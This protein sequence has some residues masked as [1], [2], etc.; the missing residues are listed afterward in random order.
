MSDIYSLEDKISNIRKVVRNLTGDTFSNYEKDFRPALLKKIDSDSSRN[1]QKSLENFLE[2]K[3]QEDKVKVYTHPPIESVAEHT[4]DY[5]KE[6]KNYSRYSFK[7]PYSNKILTSFTSDD[8]KDLSSL[9]MHDKENSDLNSL[10][11]LERENVRKLELRI[12]KKDEIIQNMNE[13]QIALTN[14]IEL[15]RIKGHEGQVEEYKNTINI[16]QEKV[17]KY[18]SQINYLQSQQGRNTATPDFKKAQIEDLQNKILILERKNSELLSNQHDF[19]TI[20]S[21]FKQDQLIASDLKYQLE[22]KDKQVV[23]LMQ[24]N[25]NL[26]INLTELQSLKKDSR[27]DFREFKL[28]EEIQRLKFENEKLAEKPQNSKVP[29]DSSK[30][31]RRSCSSNIILSEVSNYLKCPSSE[32]ISRV[33]QLKH[34]EKLEI[35]LGKLLKDLSPQTAKLSTKQIWKCIRKVIEEYLLLKKRLETEP[36]VKISQLLGVKDSDVFNE[37]KRI[38]EEKRNMNSLVEKI[39]KMLCLNPHAALREVEDT[40]DEK[41]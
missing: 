26:Q 16:L 35:R 18:L 9:K 3:Y 14:E 1:T 19:V 10:L 21:K 40:I 2:E 27:Q 31:R 11:E 28:K 17:E 37:V 36:T 41:V 34:S 4:L 24:E 5:S 12:I 15:L 38:C 22:R 23:E 39:K 32:I 20:N 30:P 7:G 25:K 6:D 29:R 13:R 8:M 33:K